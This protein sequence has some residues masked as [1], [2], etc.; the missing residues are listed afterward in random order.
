MILCYSIVPY[1]VLPCLGRAG[2][3]AAPDADDRKGDGGKVDTM[4]YLH[5]I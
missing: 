3:Q 5:N 1:S 4:I 2:A